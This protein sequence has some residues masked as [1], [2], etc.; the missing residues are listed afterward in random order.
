[1]KRSGMSTGAAALRGRGNPRAAPHCFTSLLCPLF[2]PTTYPACSIYPYD[3]C[4]P[5]LA[6][7]VARA[8]VGDIVSI[9]GA[10][11]AAIADTVAAPEVAEALPPGAL[12]GFLA[13]GSPQ[14]FSAV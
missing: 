5:L 10:P 13:L 12:A 4:L 6:V 8:V 7:D 9:A 11:A 1:M 3:S 2:L 14:T